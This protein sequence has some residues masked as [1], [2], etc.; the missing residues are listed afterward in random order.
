MVTVEQLTSAL[1]AGYDR[2]VELEATLE[3]AVILVDQYIGTSVVPDEIKDL[4]YLRVA[5]QLFEQANV[6]SQT[7]AS[8]YGTSEAPSPV[9]RNPMNTVYPI[10]RGYVLPW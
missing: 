3:Q 8:F 2:E 4:C 5:V 6:P 7:E 9:T 1:G 10:L